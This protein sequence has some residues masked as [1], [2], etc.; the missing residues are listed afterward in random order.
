MPKMT[1]D[2]PRFDRRRWLLIAM[3][4]GIAV[5][6]AYATHTVRSFL[7]T[8]PR[9]VLRP[10]QP[11]VLRDQGVTVSGAQYTSRAS[12][13]QIFNRDF[14]RSIFDINIAER[15][16]RLLAIDWIEDA[17]VSRVWPNRILVTVRERKPVAFV[18][19][20][21]QA[22]LLID[23]DGVLLSPPPR[24]NFEFPVVSGVWL[25][26]PE[27]ERKVRVQAAL[28]LLEDLGPAAK[29]VSEVNAASPEDL[30]I[31]AAVEGR[32]IELWMGDSNFG[33]RYRNFLDHYA[34]IHNNTPRATMF[35]LRI[36]DRITAK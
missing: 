7:V 5:S 6:S 4:L 16:R 34:E 2:K 31:T 17:A 12:V 24:A 22:F 26:Q 27:P 36:D 35:D 3:W 23:A 18:N 30:R 32:G 20:P 19:V 1:F 14:G 9:F 29:D 21:H 28:R 25:D 11:G 33:S 10:A 15:R 8:D 13:V